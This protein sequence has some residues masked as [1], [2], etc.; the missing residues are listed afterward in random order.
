DVGGDLRPRGAGRDADFVLLFRQR[1]AEA[2]HAEVF[3][4]LR[5]V[6]LLAERLALDDDLARDL[7]ADRR[8]L[9]LEVPDARLAG[10][11]LDD[12]LER[13]VE[14]RDVLLHEARAP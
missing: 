2:R 11:A 7:A 3:G 10:V 12:R 9:A 4:D 1:R 13:L 8:D 14:E 5:R 6:D